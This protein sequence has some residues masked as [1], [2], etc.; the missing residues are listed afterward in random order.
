MGP[1]DPMGFFVVRTSGLVP[2]TSIAG[3]CRCCSEEV[4]P[5]TKRSHTNSIDDEEMGHQRNTRP[6]T[7]THTHTNTHTH[8]HTHGICAN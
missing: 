6:D 2:S 4:K 7:C 8:T 3:P 5:T 1:M